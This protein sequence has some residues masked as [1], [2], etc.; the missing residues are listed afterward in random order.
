MQPFPKV[1]AQAQRQALATYL[2]EVYDTTEEILNG[3]ADLQ[4]GHLVDLDNS[5]LAEIRLL[6]SEAKDR[7]FLARTIAEKGQPS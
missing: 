2:V 7:L 1:I 6:V 4:S 5:E 3:V